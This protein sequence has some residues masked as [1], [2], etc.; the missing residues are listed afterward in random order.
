[1]AELSWPAKVAGWPALMI[2][3][4]AVAVATLST[5]GVDAHDN[6][7]HRGDERDCNDLEVR[8]AASAQEGGVHR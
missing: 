8:V 7:G 4:G 2:V 1:M 3:L 6:D 5:S